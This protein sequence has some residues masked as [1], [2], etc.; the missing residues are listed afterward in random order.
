MEN[1]FNYS[2][3]SNNFLNNSNNQNINVNQ[4][5]KS[6]IIIINDTSHNYIFCN[7]DLLKEKS[8]KYLKKNNVL[9]YCCIDCLIPN[10]FKDIKNIEKFKLCLKE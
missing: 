4:A 9:T 3:G 7:K 5:S 6:N 8:F 2:D 1:G 10:M